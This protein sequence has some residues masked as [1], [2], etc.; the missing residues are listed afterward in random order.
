MENKFINKIKTGD[1]CYIYKNLYLNSKYRIISNVEGII[2]LDLSDIKDKKVKAN[3]QYNLND[4][5]LKIDG[6]IENI[7]FGIRCYSN[8]TH[9]LSIEVD[10][11]IE[12][13]N[14]VMTFS[15]A[16]KKWGI[17]DSALRKVV[18]TN[19]LQERVDYRKSGNTWIITKSAMIKL[20]GYKGE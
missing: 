4:Y 9:V 11:S 2:T 19:K 7:I 1:L 3:S 17:T 10:N 8:N 13:L 15:E 20:Y 6:G 18:N 16:A 14:N 5:E 12:Y